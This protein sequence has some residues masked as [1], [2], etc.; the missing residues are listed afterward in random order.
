LCFTLGIAHGYEYLDFAAAVRFPIVFSQPYVF[1]LTEYINVLVVRGY[2]TQEEANRETIL[3]SEKILKAALILEELGRKNYNY[4]TVTHP[5]KILAF[6]Q[7]V[8][9]LPDE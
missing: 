6:A 4:V 3:I 9:N 8:M 1:H 2:E 7:A 5:E